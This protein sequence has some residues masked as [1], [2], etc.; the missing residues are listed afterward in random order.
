[1]LPKRRKREPLGIRP[2]AWIRCPGHLAFVRG[3]VCAIQGLAGHVCEGKIEA[4]HVR[5]GTDGGMSEKPSDCWALPLCAAAH[6]HQHQI[7]E[8]AFERQFGID[9]KA[10]A[11]A[12]WRASGHR[13]KFLDHPANPVR[14]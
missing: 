4:A 3:F 8:P 6:R 7:G 1:M 12:I 5:C 2:Q 13:L 9:M 10:K 14:F 11:A